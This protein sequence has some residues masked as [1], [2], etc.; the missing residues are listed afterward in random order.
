MI[1][2]SHQIL[3]RIQ[4]ALRGAQI[5]LHTSMQRGMR[6]KRKPLQDNYF[7][8]HPL[9]LLKSYHYIVYQIKFI[10]FI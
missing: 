6:A 5:R 8:P 3:T 1:K 4:G 2:K 7:M 9:F 10:I